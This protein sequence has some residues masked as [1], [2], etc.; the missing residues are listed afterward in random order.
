[1]IYLAG[2]ILGFLI[3]AFA[4][5][6]LCGWSVKSLHAKRLF[7]QIEKMYRINLASLKS[8]NDSS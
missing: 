3:L 2:Q 4:T 5:G 7:K 8:K 6:V 1:M